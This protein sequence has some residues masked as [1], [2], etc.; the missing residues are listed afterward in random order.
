MST[1]LTTR[2]QEFLTIDDREILNIQELYEKHNPEKVESLLSDLIDARMDTVQDYLVLD[3]TS[4]E[5][6][7][8]ISEWFRFHMA[9]RELQRKHK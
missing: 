5:I 3:A 1:D 7:K 4:G 2:A 6:D 9:L 8:A